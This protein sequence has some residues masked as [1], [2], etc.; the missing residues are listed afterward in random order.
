MCSQTC[1]HSLTEQI[2]LAQLRQQGRYRVF[3][4]EQRRSSAIRPGNRQLRVIPADGAFAIA[5]PEVG[6]FVEHLSLLTQGEK[7]MGKARRHPELL[8]IAGTEQRPHPL[9]EGG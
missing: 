1:T 9:A 8:V 7:A 6:G 5:V 3:L 4:R 2:R